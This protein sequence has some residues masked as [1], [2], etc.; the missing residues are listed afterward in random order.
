VTDESDLTLWVISEWKG[1]PIN[2]SPIEHDQIAWFE[3]SQLCSIEL[4]FEFYE[5]LITDALGRAHTSGLVGV[6]GSQRRS[7]D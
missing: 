5:A 4:A 1:A 2:A 7:A 3:S 6:L